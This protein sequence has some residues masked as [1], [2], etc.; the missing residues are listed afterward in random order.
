M[1]TYNLWHGFWR[2]A[3]KE[4]VLL[5]AEPRADRERRQAAQLAAL[6]GLRPDVLMAQEVHPLPWR[7]R[8]LARG[9]GHRPIHQLVSCGVRFLHVGVPWRIR[10]GLAMTAR[11]ELELERVAAPLLSGQF[12]FCS[13]W[14]GLQLEEARRAL[15][16]RVRLEDGRRLLLVTAHL[17]SSTE[18]GETRGER[19]LREVEGLLAAI[20]SARREDPTIAGVILG[21]DFNALADSGPI[22]VL[23]R[24]GFVDTA[25]RLGAE[26]ATYD[27]WSNQ[28]AA[29]MT[30]AGGGDPAHSAPRRIDFLF[31]SDELAETVRAVHIFGAGPAGERAAA[32]ASDHFGVLLELDLDSGVGTE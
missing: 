25:R 24:A 18:G 5:P 16:G 1:L 32:A 23:R 14:L 30:R 12:G 8:E 21:G 31:V 3:E 22:Q 15:L 29:Q 11:T 27:P 20:E 26:F 19:R 10:S 4:I 28:L 2:T 13:D 7:A 17:H 9:L 6:E